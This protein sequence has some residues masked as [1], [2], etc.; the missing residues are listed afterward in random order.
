MENKMKPIAVKSK[1]VAVRVKPSIYPA[2]F[3][4]LMAGREKRQI[5]EVFGLKNFGVNLTHLKPD[6]KSA[7]MHKHKTQDEFVFVVEGE[8]TLVL[9][10]GTE[11]V[12]TAGMCAGFP[13]GGQ[14][15]QLLNRSNADAWYLEIGDRSLGDEVTYPNDDIKGTQDAN[16]HWVFT[17]KDGTPY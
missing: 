8:L 14:A 17:R 1:D 2:P 13:A 16:G 4:V 9:E 6:S 12:L 11:T 10:N 5:G 7:L 15:H 3:A